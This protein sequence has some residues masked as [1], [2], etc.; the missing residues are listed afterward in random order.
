MDPVSFAGA[1]DP[2][3]YIYAA[4]TVG[5]VLILGTYMWFLAERR[6]LRAH[7]AIAKK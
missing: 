2:W 6:K 7:L 4:Y 1:T 3:P 5:T